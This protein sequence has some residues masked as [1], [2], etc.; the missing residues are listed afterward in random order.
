MK[1]VGRKDVSRYIV[2]SNHNTVKSVLIQ[3]IHSKFLEREHGF[4]QKKVLQSFKST[5]FV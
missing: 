4:H 2:P 5:L 1:T 3:V